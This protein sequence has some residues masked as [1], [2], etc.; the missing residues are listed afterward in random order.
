MLY[1]AAQLACDAARA[2]SMTTAEDVNRGQLELPERVLRDLQAEAAMMSRMRHPK[3]GRG[4]G[5]MVVVAD[6][7]AHITLRGSPLQ[8]NAP[9]PACCAVW[10]NSWGWWRCRLP[11]SQVCRALTVAMHWAA[12]GLRGSRAL[13][14]LPPA[15]EYCSRGS[16]YDCLTAAHDQPEAAAQ[17]T[18]RRRLCMAIDAGAGLLYLHCRNI[19]HRDGKGS[20]MRLWLL[21]TLCERHQCMHRAAMHSWLPPQTVCTCQG[22]SEEPQ[23][24]GGRALACQGG[25]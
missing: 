4:G 9:A 11:S 17:L 8:H 15:A 24:A 1:P 7:D 13:P 5:L 3:C 20:W 25:W 14:L 19:I 16:L 6:A 18:W 23:P 2:L 12:G 22:C 10:C 21:S